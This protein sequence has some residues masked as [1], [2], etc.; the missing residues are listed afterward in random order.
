MSAAVS[1]EQQLLRTVG[2]K[3]IIALTVNGIIGAG[4]FA[5]PA[6][7]A[8]ILG[9]ASPL[10]FLA[11]G[12]F[13]IIIVYCFAE[14]GGRY[15]RTGG[16]YL[17]ASEAFGGAAAFVIGW[18]YFLARVTSVA[19]LSGALSGFAGYFI[20]L[21]PPYRQIFSLLVLATLGYINFL[22]IRSSTRVINI[23]TLA[24]MAP[25][26]VLIVAGALLCRWD[27]YH[28][29][30]APPVPDFARA[31]L[32]CMFAFSGFEVIAIPGAE[33]KH[34]RRDIPR[35]IL[36]GS[37][38]TIVV[39]LM[40]QI[41]AVAALP[42]IAGSSRPLAEAAENLMG[43]G[44]G[45]LLTVGAICST[46]GT[47]T[48]LLLVGPRILF[49]MAIAGQMPGPFSHIHHRFRSPDVSLA[50]FLAATACLMLL[51]DFTNL[52]T[53]SAMAR[54]VTYIGSAL[55]LLVLRKKKPVTEGFQS[56][57]GPFLP[58]L[59]VLVSLYLL[60]AATRDQWI[61]GTGA[62]VVGFLLYGIAALRKAPHRTPPQ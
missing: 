1:S 5:L 60:T 4:I 10:A 50:A 25:L 52:A 2:L 41:V 12:L 43:S 58:L 33:M 22:G 24:K 46:V 9:P 11:A 53:L 57:G 54:L 18:M 7:T 14:L 44:G 62:L 47:L 13:M 48:S 20:E 45:V 61:Y 35:G 17:Y 19:A 29:V 59:T 3:D 23:L 6:T 49:A 30:T 37:A 26:L 39:Y 28:H 40:I 34:P 56:P 21:L 31:L 15:D 8:A 16:A 27:V 36:I 42:G 38:I 55:A 32:V 51:S